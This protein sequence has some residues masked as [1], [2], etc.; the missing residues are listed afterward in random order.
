MAVWANVWATA[1]NDERTRRQFIIKIRKNN[2]TEISIFDRTRKVYNL[3]SL[4]LRGVETHSRRTSETCTHSRGDP[5][6]YG[7]ENSFCIRRAIKIYWILLLYF[8]RRQRITG[9]SI[10]Y[11]VG[12]G[13]RGG[14]GDGLRVK[15]DT[16][17]NCPWCAGQ[18]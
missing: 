6:S 18:R 12:C 13:E 9:R 16:Y 7:P 2:T 15:T 5:S 14:A 17:G 1:K 3:F 11:R 8:I 4:Y 10:F